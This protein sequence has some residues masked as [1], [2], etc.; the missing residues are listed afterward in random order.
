M[1][2]LFLIT[3]FIGFMSCNNQGNQ[4]LTTKEKVLPGVAF[5]NNTLGT[6]KEV[7]KDKFK[8]PPLDAAT[9]YI[10]KHKDEFMKNLE[11]VEEVEV[12][13]DV[14]I[15]FYRTSIAADTYK[16]KM[17]F[18]KMDGLYIPYYKYYSSYSDDPFKNGKGEEAKA[19]LKKADEWE[20][21]TAW[22]SE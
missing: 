12:Q 5:Q 20:K 15:V 16:R 7:Y 4:D 14:F 11:I 2:S 21:N 3:L 13:K 6:L 1:K 10:E 18:R 8:F 19:L 17:Y 9:Y 22:W